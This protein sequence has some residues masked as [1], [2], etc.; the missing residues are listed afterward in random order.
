[1]RKALQAEQ[2]KAEMLI[3]IKQLDDTCEDLE[4]EVNDL[5][6]KITSLLKKEKRDKELGEQRHQEESKQ[7]LDINQQYKNSLKAV[8][9]N[10]NH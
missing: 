7:L 9:T 6:R 5:K 3:K 10:I 1:M 2:R 4:N 8:L